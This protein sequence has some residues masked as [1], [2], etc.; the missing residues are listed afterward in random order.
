MGVTW[1]WHESRSDGWHESWRDEPG[2]WIRWHD[3]VAALCTDVTN[4]SVRCEQSTILSYESRGLFA[5]VTSLLS[6]E[7]KLQSNE[8][9]LLANFSIVLA[10]VA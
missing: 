7:S 5:D 9:K 10:D 4:E 6:Y 8:S 2:E 3:G 1:W